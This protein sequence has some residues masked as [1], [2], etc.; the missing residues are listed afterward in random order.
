MKRAHGSVIMG[1]YGSKFRE[2]CGAPTRGS[3]RCH[4]EYIWRHY[5]E[6]MRK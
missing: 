3:C 5:E 4:E 2:A 6:R 1:A